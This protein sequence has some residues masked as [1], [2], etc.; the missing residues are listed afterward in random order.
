MSSPDF[1]KLPAFPEIFTRV[2]DILLAR[3]DM[4]SLTTLIRTS[5]DLA[6]YGSAAIYARPTVNERN[7]RGFLLGLEAD[8]IK[9]VLPAFAKKHK[10]KNKGGTSRYKPTWSSATRKH[11]QL[12]LVQE[13]E[14]KQVPTKLARKAGPVDK[15]VVI[16]SWCLTVA[17]GL[18]KRIPSLFYR[19]RAIRFLGDVDS[20]TKKTADDSDYKFK[21]TIHLA[22][23]TPIPSEAEDESDADSQ[24]GAAAASSPSFDVCIRI[25]YNSPRHVALRGII[26]I[27]DVLQGI[28]AVR[29]W[30]DRISGWHKLQNLTIHAPDLAIL[31]GL[32]ILHWRGGLRLYFTRQLRQ[33]PG[34]ASKPAELLEEEAGAY[35]NEMKATMDGRTGSIQILGAFD[36]HPSLSGCTSDDLRKLVLDKL[37]DYDMDFMSNSLPTT[38]TAPIYSPYPIF[39]LAEDPIE[40]WFAPKGYGGPPCLCDGAKRITRVITDVSRHLRSHS[41]FSPLPLQVSPQ[42]ATSEGH[43][44][45]PITRPPP[46]RPVH[47]DSSRC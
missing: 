32:D 44:D 17:T 4:S 26:T 24:A 45:L 1:T 38:K 36:I 20:G 31:P 40:Y 43:V 39:S 16:L 27:G 28:G 14:L 7:I 37:A 11:V 18:G 15:H 22:P 6:G 25:E 42:A 12:M 47:V 2:C 8:F 23:Y 5:K 34:S 9:D 19:L 35:L 13:L 33:T 3:D 41:S 21:A 30:L 10:S 29:A 46:S